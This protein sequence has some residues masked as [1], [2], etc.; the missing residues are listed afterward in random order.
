MQNNDD[1]NDS[2]HDYSWIDIR[3]WRIISLSAFVGERLFCF[4]K[5]SLSVA[6]PNALSKSSRKND[7]ACP[8]DV[9]Q[10]SINFNFDL[11]PVST[12]TSAGTSLSTSGD[13]FLK[14]SFHKLSIWSYWYFLIFDKSLN[15]QKNF[16]KITFSVVFIQSGNKCINVR[17]NWRPMVTDGN[18]T[19]DRRIGHYRI[20]NFIWNCITTIA[21]LNKFNVF[22]VI[23]WG[24]LPAIHLWEYDKRY[25]M[26]V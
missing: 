16:V 6:L 12:P 21:A 26:A 20:W 18:L 24:Q 23:L 2:Y 4:K 25:W 5:Q 11:L 10:G 13:N 8:S 17:D 9:F 7:Q 19:T 22:K 3:A 14:L 15:I 1:R